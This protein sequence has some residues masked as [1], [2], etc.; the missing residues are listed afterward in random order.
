MQGLSPAPLQASI[1]LL[2]MPGILE[3]L[4]HEASPE[5][6]QRKP[7]PERWSIQEVLAHLAV[8]K[9]P[10]SERVGRI[11][12]E[13][14]PA[15]A[16]YVAPSESQVQQKTARQHFIALRRAHVVFLHTVPAAA[17]GR[18]GRHCE[19]GSIRVSQL[20]HE[21]AHH[22]LGHLRQLT[23]LYRAHAFCPHAGPFQKFSHLKP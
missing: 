16:N 7:A 17:A 10:Y 3:H 20:L 5:L 22:D 6:L 21:L 4:L 15:L 11:V 2:E 19:M 9:Q 23:E 1:S 18:T 14:D 12:M 8:I 13:E